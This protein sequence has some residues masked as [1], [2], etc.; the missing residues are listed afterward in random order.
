[1][2]L[3]IGMNP[4]DPNSHITRSFIKK[5]FRWTDVL[6]DRHLP[7]KPDKVDWNQWGKEV[8]KYKV[9]RIQ[10]IMRTLAFQEDYEAA[11]PRKKVAEDRVWDRY[12]RLYA[13]VEEVMIIPDLTD[14]ELVQAAFE[15]AQELG[16][17]VG[18]VPPKDDYE[19]EKLCIHYLIEMNQSWLNSKSIPAKGFGRKFMLEMLGFSLHKEIVERYP[20]FKLAADSLHR[21]GMFKG[22]QQ[23]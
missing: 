14:T 4:L 21:A 9:S 12:E 3:F 13:Q 5:H 10:S 17:I 8:K 2:D 11:K 15:W 19:F 1:M 7:A 6:L 22:H 16:L 20:T 23:R 18:S